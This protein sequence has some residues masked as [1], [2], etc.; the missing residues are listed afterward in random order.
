MTEQ[1]QLI[2]IIE[3]EFPTTLKALRA[4]PTA[5]SELKPSTKS[6]SARELAHTFV[7]GA[8]VADMTLDGA[9]QL[10]KVPALGATLDS[11]IAT[12]D[13]LH[14]TFVDRLKRT[15]DA[16]LN[17]TVKFFAGPKRMEDMRRADVLWFLLMDT[18][19]HRGQWSVYLRL[20]DAKV[21][22]IY[23]PTADEPWQ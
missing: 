23:G 14:H 21:P 11:I 13:S 15:S 4:Y 17:K 19:H 1:E 2:N 3:R 6:K 10:E 18:V 8:K 20:A 22:S 5:K 12:Y 9:L 16:D 7:F